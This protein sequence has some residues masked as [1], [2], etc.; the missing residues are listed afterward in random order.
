MK[1]TEETLELVVVRVFDKEEIQHCNGEIKFMS[2]F[3]VN[4][5]DIW[6]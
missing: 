5:L 4:I 2:G 6:E 1:F 3:L